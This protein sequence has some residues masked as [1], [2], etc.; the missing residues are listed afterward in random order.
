LVAFAL[1]GCV[2]TPPTAREPDRLRTP[3][4]A[5]DYAA[6]ARDGTGS[7]RAQAF[8]RQRGGGVVTCAGSTAFLLPHAEY[9]LEW[10]WYMRERRRVEHDE[11]TMAALGRVIRRTQCDAQGNFGFDKLP[12]G[13]YIVITEVTW[14]VAGRRQGGSVMAAVTIA[15]GG[16]ESMILSDPSPLR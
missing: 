10:T 1:T 4:V 5:A 3:F 2:A 6:F 7:L 13:R 9:F 12:G 16:A 11:Q 14:D 8:L 15:D